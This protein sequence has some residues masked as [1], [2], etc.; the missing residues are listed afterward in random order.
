MRS[1]PH[2]DGSALYV[3]EGKPA[4]GDRVAVRLRVPA[5]GTER[6]VLVRTVRDGEPHLEPARLESADDDERWY[7]TEVKVHNPVTRYRFLLDEPGGYRWVTGRGVIARDVPDAGD[8]RLTV[9]PGAPGWAR[10]GV[11]YQVF[12]DRFAC[13][14]VPR[15]VPAWAVPTDWDTEPAAH[16]RITGRQLYGGDLPGIEAHLDHVQHL[17]ADVIYLTPFFPGR[18]THRYDATSF[19]HVDPLL[20]GDEAL[21]S[22]TRAVHGRG[23]RVVGD[24]TTNHT[25]VG[26]EWFLRGTADP[27]SEEAGYYHRDDEGAVGWL[28]HHS[29]PKLDHRAPGLRRRMLDGP[30]SV[31]GRWLAEPFALDGWR[32]DVANMTG[33]YR[34][35]ELTGEVARAMRATIAQVRP[36]GVVIGEHFHDATADLVGDGWHGVMNY[37]AFARPVWGWL[38]PGDR[39]ETEFPL[40]LGRRSGHAMVGTMRDFAAMVPW[41]VTAG[42]WNLLG[43]HDTARIRTLLGDPAL[44]EVAV[45]LL[46]TYP[47]APM[48]F[49]G[50]EIGATGCNGEHSRV[51]MPW[52][53]PERWDGAVLDTYRTL[54]ALRGRSSALRDGG[55]RWV[56]AAED[57]VA[58]LRESRE[59]RVLVVAARRPWSGASLPA[60]LA[61]ERTVERWYGPDLV[62]DDDGVHVPGDGPAVGVWRLA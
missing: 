61:P 13:S 36:D 58:F 34:D 37:A 30:E 25:G 2:H 45:G 43:S 60:A 14:G 8:F 17:G 31:V 29:L 16:G 23:M 28:G 5:S 9:F 1:E 24:L 12:P 42:Q 48:V 57:A 22:L 50:D 40:P 47:G 39:V 49:A 35:V 55:M 26:H 41:A 7:V 19:A 21:V 10:H 52:D 27:D 3:D 33:R 32:V 15:D 20:G 59:E 11:V 18:S 56:L 38:A 62:A 51:A 54:L 6:G 44:V 53:R 4:L 46:A